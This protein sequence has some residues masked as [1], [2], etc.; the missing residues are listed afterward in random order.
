MG[1]AETPLTVLIVEDE[2]LISHLV[3]DWLNDWGF[4]VHE[5]AS[6]DE[7][8]AYIDHDG[9]VDVIFTDLNLPGSIDGAEL[10]ARVRAQRPELPIVYAS[11]RY[12]ADDIA[13]LVACSVFVPKPYNP[14]DVCSL[15]A[16]LTGG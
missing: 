13:P 14:A 8:L 2:T 12:S 11:S 6:G 4:A 3:A 16:R 7:A 9:P 10:A 5:A 15:L 1:R